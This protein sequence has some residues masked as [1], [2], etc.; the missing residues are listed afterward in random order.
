MRP[1][2]QDIESWQQAELLMQPAFIRLLDNIRKQL[3]ESQWQGT[4]QD[5]PV[6]AEAVSDEVKAQVR[7]LQAELKTATPDRVEA[8]EQALA[9]LPTP[10]PGYEL[11]L[12]RDDRQVSIDMWEICYQICFQ[13][14]ELGQPVIIDQSLIDATGD[15]DWNC[16]DHKVKTI[17]EKFFGD[18]PS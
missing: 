17:V 10:H 8:I 18:L 9:A 3:D 15:V 4:Y 7:L 5:V 12:Q 13:A 14:L 2:F 11:C 6:W 16:L 1:K